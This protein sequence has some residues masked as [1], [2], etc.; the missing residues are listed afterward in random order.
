MP[1]KTNWTAKIA[2]RDRVTH[3][4]L[5]H[6]G[7]VISME[8][9]SATI[10][11]EDGKE[12]TFEK[13]SLG[14]VESFEQRVAGMGDTRDIFDE[15]LYYTENLEGLVTTLSDRVE[16]LKWKLETFKVKEQSR[17]YYREENKTTKPTDKNPAWK[18]FDRLYTEYEASLVCEALKDMGFMTIVKDKK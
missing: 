12:R 3:Y 2:I 8:G 9:S 4:A 15:L 13:D 6:E 17:V 10:A 14:V 5:P 1:S 16:Y 7:I 11:C 18:M